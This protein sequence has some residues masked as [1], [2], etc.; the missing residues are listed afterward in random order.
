MPLQYTWFPQVTGFVRQT[1]QAGKCDVVMGYAQGDE[2]V[3]NTNHYYT[4]THVI[5]VRA[6]GDLADVDTLADPRLKGRRIGVVA[7]SPPATHV[8]R[9]GLM[10]DAEPYHLMTDRRVEDPAGQMLA[11]LEAGKIDA[12]LLWGPIGGPLVKQGASRA[13]GD[14]APEGAGAAAARLPHHH[15]GAGRRGRVEAR[16]QQPDPAQR[17]R[18]STRSCATRGCR[19][20]TTSARARSRPRAEL[21]AAA[22]AA[23]LA[24]AP[25][26]A[27][28]PLPRPSPATRPES[29]TLCGD[30]AL[31][32]E[33]LAPIAEDGGCGVARPVRLEAAAGVTLDPPA[34]L[35]CA[36]ARALA[37]WLEREAIPAFSGKGELA[38]LGVA[39]AYACRNRNRAATGKLSEHARGNALDIGSFTLR[40]GRTLRVGDGWRSAEWGDT[41]RRLRES[42]CGPVRHGPRPGV[43]PAARRPPAS[44]RRG[45][46]LRPL[47]RIGAPPASASAPF[48]P[49]R[50]GGG[51]ASRSP[52]G[53]P[54]RAA[55]PRGSS[56]RRPMSCI[57]M[58]SP[59][60]EKPTGTLSAGRPARVAGV[61]TSIHWW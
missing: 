42:A 5:V 49:A 2:M 35:A 21:A 38:A 15:G 3:L 13:E 30:P 16:A 11:D 23:L 4:S 10:K 12:A 43:E 18:R 50:A 32:G 1:L 46:A 14:A 60:A 51:G 17:R 39:D 53:R 27:E 37:A 19:S 9:L 52:G 44:R 22:L 59:S 41:L 33:T 24:A 58:G 47:V 34:V 25:A 54:R 7:G 45:A 61:T 8:A 36:T 56:P 26:R 31:L 55:A 28:G 29:A 40:D 20:S 48:S 6:D 57:P